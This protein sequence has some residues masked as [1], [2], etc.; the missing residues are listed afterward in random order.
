MNLEA[1]QEWI[2][3][4][5]MKR[6]SCAAQEGFRIGSERCQS[7][8]IETALKRIFGTHVDTAQTPLMIRL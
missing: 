2:N 1:A 4:T 8:L 7:R 3:E 6:V 5:N